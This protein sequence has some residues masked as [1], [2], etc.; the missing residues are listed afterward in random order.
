MSKKKKIPK[1]NDE[2]YFKYIMS[3]KGDTTTQNTYGELSIP[4]TLTKPED[5]NKES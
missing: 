1:L 2:Q 3:L 4:T 5:S